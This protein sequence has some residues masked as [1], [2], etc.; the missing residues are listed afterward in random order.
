MSRKFS[1]ILLRTRPLALRLK[2]SGYC[3]LN[4][5]PDALRIVW[6]FHEPCGRDRLTECLYGK[7]ILMLGIRSRQITHGNG[8]PDRM[9]IASAGDRPDDLAPESDCL[10]AIEQKRPVTIQREGAELPFR[11]ILPDL[12]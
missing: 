12:Q 8:L 2:K 10:P 7:I 6:D 4:Q 11:S 5:N 9:A 3:H 1:V